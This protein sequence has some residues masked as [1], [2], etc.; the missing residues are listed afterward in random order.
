MLQSAPRFAPHHAEK[1]LGIVFGMVLNISECQARMKQHENE[2]C[3]VGCH[4]KPYALQ[5]K[6]DASNIKL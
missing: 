6:Q 3:I 1:V 5:T 4:P 2:R